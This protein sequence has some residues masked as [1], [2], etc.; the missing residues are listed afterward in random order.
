MKD[1]LRQGLDAVFEMRRANRQAA[2][3]A[4][5]A[6]EEKKAADLTHFETMKETVIRPA[7][8]EIVDYL[9]GKDESCAISTEASRP[10]NIGIDFF[11]G[12]SRR[13]ANHGPFFGVVV[14]PP[15]NVVRF[16]QS[17]IDGSGTG[18]RAMSGSVPIS[19]LTKDLVQEKIL[20][21]ISGL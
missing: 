21:F 14:E 2:D 9:K 6:A 4:K 7:M 18:P 5:L 17:T 10:P 3:D 13:T 20:S 15:F 19:E 12:P 8:A 16:Y 1:E 11:V